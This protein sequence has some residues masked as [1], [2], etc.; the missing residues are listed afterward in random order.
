MVFN[1]SYTLRLQSWKLPAFSSTFVVGNK[2]P[3]TKYENIAANMTW[4][5]MEMR[6][7]GV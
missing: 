5:Y 1:T 4:I 2:H 7:S 6:I 3:Y